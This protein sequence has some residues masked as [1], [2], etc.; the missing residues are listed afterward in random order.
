MYS[1]IPEI[2]YIERILDGCEEIWILCSS[3]KNRCFRDV[4]SASCGRE[5]NRSAFYVNFIPKFVHN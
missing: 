1:V 3:G 4:T 2:I 5:F